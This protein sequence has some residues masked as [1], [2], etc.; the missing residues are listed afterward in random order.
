[1]SNAASDATA[2]ARVTE[3]LPR[4]RHGF[5]RAEV[6]EHQ[7]LRILIG[8]VEAMRAQGYANTPVADI[9]ERAGVSR[10]TFYQQFSGKLDCFL[11]AFDL[12]ADALIAR[13][14]AALDEPGEPLELLELALTVYLDS[15]A[16]QPGYARLFLVEVYAAGPEAVARRAAVQERIVDGLADLLGARTKSGRFACQMLVA[17]VSTMVTAP[18]V[19]DDVESL[20]A[21]RRPLLRHARRLHAAGAFDGR[22]RTR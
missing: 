22:A 9:L 18:L 12:V 1:M 2:G 21:L 15:L 8:V 6:S 5:T 20:R 7:R 17:A 16:E 19:A 14:Q 3:Q 4:G 10:E 11:A 13:L